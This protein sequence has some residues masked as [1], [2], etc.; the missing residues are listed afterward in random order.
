M[1]KMLFSSLLVSFLFSKEFDHSLYFPKCD[2]KTF[3]RASY[4]L[5]YDENYKGPLFISY[6]TMDFFQDEELIKSKFKLM[7]DEEINEDYRL[8]LYD[9]S[10]EEDFLPTKLIPTTSA[11]FSEKGK[12]DSYLLSN[13]VPMNEQTFALWKQIDE[14]EKKYLD[15]FKDVFIIS[16]VTYSG[17][18]LNKKIYMPNAYYKIFYVPSKT[19]IIG[20]YLPLEKVYAYSS[21]FKYQ[22][23]ID[24]I[25]EKAGIDFFSLLPDDIENKIESVKG[26]F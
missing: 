22:Q 16:G 2:F 4:T 20:F 12:R 19:K 5:C 18:K 25:E 6:N 26:N 7:A 10:N 3:E 23:S 8:E 24:F 21:I 14:L 9:Y 17:E 1:K 11:Y 13:T 15:K